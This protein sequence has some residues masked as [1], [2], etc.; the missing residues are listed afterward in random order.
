MSSWASKTIR[1]KPRLKQM[2]GYATDTTQT[3]EWMCTNR[4]IESE[5]IV[6]VDAITDA[7]LVLAI[8][9]SERT[10]LEWV[11]IHNKRMLSLNAICAMVAIELYRNNNE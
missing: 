3:E 8:D 6:G 4:K 2:S 9:G 10:K 1:Y 11:M 5:T 7:V